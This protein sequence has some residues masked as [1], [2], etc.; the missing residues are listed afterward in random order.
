[1]TVMSEGERTAR[2][3]WRRWLGSFAGQLV[4]A[5]LV[6]GLILSF[7]AKPYAVPSASMD[8]TLLPGDRVLVNRLAYRFSQPRTGDIVVFDAGAAWDGASVRKQGNSVKAAVKAVWSWSGF[9]PT[10]S[11]TLVKR[12]IAT[13]GQTASCC[14]ANGSVVVNGKPLEEPYLGSNL[15][16]VPGK[17]D[18]STSPRSLRCFGAVTVPKDSYLM[19]GDNRAD[20]SDSAYRC[21]SASASAVPKDCWRWATRDGIVGRASV[22]MWPLGRVHRLR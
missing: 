11:H 19:L 13:G 3:W 20:S 16:F 8:Q 6:I 7:V 14:S 10:G 4:L 1:M 18:C 15:P 22:L 17:L 2:P 5:V 12:V 21:R 9:G